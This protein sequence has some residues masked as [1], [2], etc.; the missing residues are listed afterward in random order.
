MHINASLDEVSKMLVIVKFFSLETHL[1]CIVLS[2]FLLHLYLESVSHEN[3]MDPEQSEHPSFLL[4]RVLKIVSLPTENEKCM[5]IPAMC[6]PDRVLTIG[7][8]RP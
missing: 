8:K 6:K 1:I 3:R 5:R 4:H 7:R 2:K